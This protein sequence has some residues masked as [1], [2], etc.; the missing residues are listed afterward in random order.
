MIAELIVSMALRTVTA[1]NGVPE[2]TDDT[3][4][5]SASGDDICSARR[6]GAHVCAA[7]FVP[8]GSHLAILDTS[9]MTAYECVVL[10]RMNRRYP[11]RVDIFM[12]DDIARARSFGIQK[13]LVYVVR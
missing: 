10:D 12:G 8:L 7:N 5:I 3:P 2:Q 11:N 4:C 1:Y 6:W 9:S 13:L